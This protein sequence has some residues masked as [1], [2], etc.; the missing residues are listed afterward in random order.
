M[1]KIFFFLVFRKIL[2]NH[3]CRVREN[4][5]HYVTI[6]GGVRPH[7]WQDRISSNVLASIVVVCE[8]ACQLSFIS[9]SHQTKL[10]TA[11]RPVAYLCLTLT[12]LVLSK[13]T[14]HR[15]NAPAIGLIIMWLKPPPRRDSLFYHY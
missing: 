4:F 10:M 11:W 12:H 9:S 1:I 3:H 5:C 7:L 13:R 14:Q 15:G 6:R 8:S 2:S